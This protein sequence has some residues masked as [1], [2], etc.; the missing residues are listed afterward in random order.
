MLLMEQTY[1]SIA[2][3]TKID[4]R[5]DNNGRSMIP[6]RMGKTKPIAPASGAYPGRTQSDEAL[7]PGQ[8]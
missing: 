6:L 5:K 4:P 1:L 8:A 3:R 2:L 7:Q